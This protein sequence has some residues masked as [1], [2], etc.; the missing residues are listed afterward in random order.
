MKQTQPIIIRKN[1]KS[2]TKMQHHSGAW[3]VAYADFVTAM[4]AFFLLLW[5]VSVSNKATLEGI[6][7]YFTP[8]KAI[9]KNA[10]LG[11][12]GGVNENLTHGI[13]ATHT[14]SSSLIYGSPSTGHRM[15]PAKLPS[16]MS[17]IE[18]EHFLNIMNTMQNSSELKQFADNLR[19]DMSNEGLRIQI[20]D[21]DH[22]PMFKPNTHK[23]QPYMETIINIISKMINKQSN[24]I[25]ISGHTAF[26]RNNRMDY[27]Q[28]SAD[29]ANEVRKL[30][31]KTLS[32]KEQVVKIIGLAD[33]EPLDGLSPGDARNIRVDITLLNQSSISQYQKSTPY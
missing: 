18:Q 17:K 29:R 27:W 9:S 4:M 3:K 21:N 30:M 32:N 26:A 22:R 2:Y 10:G 33:R 14:A 31:N 15:D 11:F 24:Y 16:N 5:L 12:D 1:K 6:A 13:A 25:S 7:K 8:T 20:M 19:I 23:L 28:L